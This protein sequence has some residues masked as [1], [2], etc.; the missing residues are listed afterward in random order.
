MDT[1][2]LV[3][4]IVT[5]C[6]RTEFL[7]EALKSVLDQTFQSFEIIVTDD[8]DNAEI[9]A[10]CDSFRQQIIR[11]RSNCSPLGVALNLRGAILEAR[12]K[13]VAILNDDDKWESDFLDRLV[14]PLGQSSERVLSFAD[15]WIMRRG[16]EIDVLATD[17][18]TAKYRRSGLAEGEILDWRRDA[19]LYQCVP[20]AMA[21]VFRKDV[22]NWDLLVREVEGA[23]DYWITCLLA[24]TGRPAYYVS[25]RLSEYRIHSAMETARQAADKNENMIFIFSRL[26]ELRLFP[27]LEAALRERHRDALFTC[28]KEHL[29]FEEVSGARKFFRESLSTTVSAKALAAWLLTFLPSWLRKKALEAFSDLK[30]R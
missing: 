2:P 5:V 20:L 17:K 19:V 22:V 23:Y 26:L 14:D 18:N 30:S 16:G 29:R 3:T 1:T 27:Q 13:Y 28:G 4:A 15:H 10:I 12:G 11:Y 9:K 8:S 25:K 6:D 24:S 21:A 7:R